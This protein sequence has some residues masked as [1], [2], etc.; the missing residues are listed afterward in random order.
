MKP[1]KEYVLE[2][3]FYAKEVKDYQF[4][5]PIELEHFGTIASPTI[6]CKGI[7]PQFIFDPQ[8]ID[9]KRKVI[10]TPD[11]CFPRFI[12]VTLTNPD[13]KAILWSIDDSA[14]LKEQIFSLEHKKGR[15][16]PG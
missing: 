3:K 10:T 1:Q 7:Q 2:V 6:R 15:L 12:N 4:R 8:I 9:F 11:K 16:G 13:K 14:I 5:L